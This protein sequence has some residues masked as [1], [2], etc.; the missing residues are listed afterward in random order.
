[1]TDLLLP[2]NTAQND[3]EWQEPPIELTDAETLSLSSFQ[4]PAF[5]IDQL[6]KPGLAVLAG[7]PK[8][9]KSWLVLDICQQVASGKPL[10]GLNTS[11]GSVMYIALEDSK[12][13]L[14]DRLLSITDTPSDRLYVATSCPSLSDGLEDAVIYFT[15]QCSDPKL[16]VIDTFQM[17]RSARTEISYAGDY[18]ETSQLKQL[19]DRLGICILLV[20]HT[21]KMADSDTIS[22]I[23]GTNGIAGCAD[24]LMVLKKPK[25]TENKATLYFTGRDITDR[26]LTLELD[27]ESCKWKHVSGELPK[28]RSLPPEIDRLWEHMQRVTRYE[29]DNSGFAEQFSAFCGTQINPAVL[30]RIMNRY[31]FELEERG[32]TFISLRTRKGRILSVI[33]SEKLDKLKHRS[34]NPN[35]DIPADNAGSRMTSADKGSE[36]NAPEDNSAQQH[37]DN[38]AEQPEPCAGASAYEAAYHAEYD[39]CA[40][41][42]DSYDGYIPPR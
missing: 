29:G 30:K 40:R 20:H 16:V 8:L 22:E 36:G 10:W 2:E 14:Q 19:A 32:V 27:R 33:Y 24:T 25:R 35:K 37:R 28:H 6:L 5:I 26:E 23:S 34:D 18:S 9:G 7:A 12:A 21:R 38:P 4:R 1:M 3:V 31:R 17:I 41:D 39:E 15:E 42:F 13:R 11:G